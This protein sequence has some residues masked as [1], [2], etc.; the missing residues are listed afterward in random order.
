MLEVAAAHGHRTIVL[1]AWGC[2]VFRNDPVMVADAFAQTLR[3]VNKFDHVVFAILDGLPGAAVF[4]A[5][6]ARFANAAAWR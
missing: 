4:A 3:A 1:G 6:N 5:F 2:G